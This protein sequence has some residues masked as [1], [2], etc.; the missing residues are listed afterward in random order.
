M[1][2]I[3]KENEVSSNKDDGI[4][5]VDISRI[6]NRSFVDVD[7]EEW[8]MGLRLVRLRKF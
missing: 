7:K 5:P 8:S 4:E 6:Q 1:N 2:V 3:T